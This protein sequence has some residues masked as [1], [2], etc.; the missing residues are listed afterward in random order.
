MTLMAP[1]SG[2]YKPGI[3]LLCH[4]QLNTIPESTG[5]EQSFTSGGEPPLVLVPHPRASIRD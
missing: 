3:E 2:H 5:R 4:C 1:L